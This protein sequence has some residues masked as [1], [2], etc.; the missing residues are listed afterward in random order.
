[1]RAVFVWQ[2]SGPND[3]PPIEGILC[4]KLSTMTYVPASIAYGN[5]AGTLS[6]LVVNNGFGDTPAN[7]SYGTLYSYTAQGAH[8][9]QTRTDGQ[10]TVKTPF[11][12]MHGEAP[13]TGT[14]DGGGQASAGAYHI[15]QAERD[16]RRVWISSDIEDSYRRTEDTTQPTGKYRFNHPPPGTC[17]LVAVTG[18]GLLNERNPDG[19]ITVDSVALWDSGADQWMAQGIFTG[20][21]VGFTDPDFDWTFPEGLVGTPNDAVVSGDESININPYTGMYF[22][23][24]GLMLGGLRN[25]SGMSSSNTIYLKVTDL[26]DNTTARNSYTVNWHLPY[27]KLGDLDDGPAK[28][29][30]FHALGQIPNGQG[31]SAVVVP[32]HPIDYAAAIDGVLVIASAAGLPTD[33]AEQLLG[34]FQAVMNLSEFGETAEEVHITDNQLFAG[35]DA[36]SETVAN[37]PDHIAGMNQTFRNQILSDHAYD[38][39]HA[40]DC[41]AFRVR[42]HHTEN[43]LADKYDK[44]GFHSP[45]HTLSFDK[46][47]HIGFEYYYVLHNATAPDTGDFTTPEELPE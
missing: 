7:N 46:T 3:N 24:N 29:N 18:A 28:E 36:W 5:P 37:S 30:R 34:I 32:A 25:G 19:S 23:S 11:I 39:W 14:T 13:I 43:T 40:Y 21:Q 22:D 26:A 16:S 45:D 15:Y 6:N 42:R 9:V 35:N 12:T 47:D 8:L 41:Y 31:I 17:S 27:E 2:P 1:V 10:T 33:E 38:E 44:H 4:V 20:N